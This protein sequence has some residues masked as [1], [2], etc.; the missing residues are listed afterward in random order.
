MKKVSMTHRG[1]KATLI[2]LLA[3]MAIATTYP[4]KALDLQKMLVDSISNHPEVKEKIYSFRRINSDIEIAESGWKPSVDL[5][6]S[7]G[8]Y[9]T[10]SPA[11]GG[12]SVDYDSTSV[13][14]ALTQNLFNGY[15]T[16]YQIE[17]T[18]ARASAALF[19]IY[20]TAN[21]LALR[22]TQT[23]LGV[24]EQS[25][26]YQ[27]ATENVESHEK[28]LSQIRERNQS[29]VG[30]RSQLQQTE[31]RVA[32]AHSSMIAQHNNLQDA[33]T[34]LHQILG[35]YVDPNDLV[36]PKFP[37]MTSRSLDALINR[38]LVEHPAMQVA[39]S[40]IRAAQA[41]HKRTLKSRYPN[42]DLRL[43][44]EYGNDIG[45]ILGDTEETSIVVNLSYNL[46]KGGRNQAEQQGKVDAI[47]EQKE[48]A[49]RVRRQ[50]INS[51]RLSWMADQSLSQQ[52]K[53]LK[54][55]V[56]KAEQTAASYTEE[57]F[58][59]QR[60]LIDLLDAEN[61]LNSAKNQQTQAKFEGLRSRYRV[62]EGFGQLLQVAGIDFEI[63]KNQ[64]RLARLNSNQTTEL[65]L[66]KDEDKDGKS[67]PYD[68]C[69]NSN[70]Q[71]RLNLFGCVK[72]NASSA[73]IK[74]EN[75]IKPE[76]KPKI[77]PLPIQEKTKLPTI[78]QVAKKPNSQ[79][80]LADDYFEMETGAVLIITHQQLLANDTDEDADTLEVV[81]V[82]QPKNGKLAYNGNGNLIYRGAEDYVGFDSFQYTATDHKSDKDSSAVAT[83]KI[84]IKKPN[85]IN[86]SKTQLVKN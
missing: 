25:R 16:T 39:A 57:F 2:G 61:E 47:Y 38:A 67:D 48:F 20:D 6:A 37:A 70:S 86:L 62:F 34:E 19:D 83:V 7:T 66:L 64:I 56:Q 63:E 50:V 41:D 22:A 42:I 77:T 1:N 8:L 40:N 29:G 72:P 9:E 69:D 68:H 52:L 30:R 54:T 51:L 58:I 78:S 14:L 5:T 15:D 3:A 71:T 21:S 12:L 59:G 75:K 24:L 85:V 45:G 23:Y 74:S 43:A 73:K 31:G 17:Q 44:T 27:L 81:K 53:Y 28:I 79:P 76:N 13:E 33:L 32:K 60:D 84:N 10:E 55:H 4:A 46:Y 35:R 82:D 65:P 36:E 80:A 26:L 49:A 18:K 11:T